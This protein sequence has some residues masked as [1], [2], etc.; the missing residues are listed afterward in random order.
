M[1]QKKKFKLLKQEQAVTTMLNKDLSNRLQ[2][3]SAKNEALAKETKH[4][5]L[6]LQKGMHEMTVKNENLKTKITNLESINARLTAKN[7]LQTTQLRHME[8]RQDKVQRTTAGNERTKHKQS[9]L[10]KEALAIRLEL[11]QDQSERA[12][13]EFTMR[14]MGKLPENKTET[15]CKDNIPGNVIKDIQLSL[16]SGEYTAHAGE[17]TTLDFRNH[18]PS[19]TT[20]QDTMKYPGHQKRNSINRKTTEGSLI[21]HEEN[22]EALFTRDMSNQDK[23]NISQTCVNIPSTSNTKNKN[24][25]IQDDF[26]DKEKPNPDLI[27]IKDKQEVTLEKERPNRGEVDLSFT[28]YAI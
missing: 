17:R 24:R 18:K 2:E 5:V 4:R 25:H 6:S 20:Q 12:Q 26:K 14:A 11:G 16:P 15:L 21:V 19:T 9:I 27:T 22:S 8:E 28:Q 3:A 23:K 1:K 13:D 7:E 10:Q